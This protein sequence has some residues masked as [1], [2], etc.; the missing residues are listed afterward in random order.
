M[1]TATKIY[2]C[3]FSGSGISLLG[4]KFW[5]KGLK[6]FVCGW[7]CGRKK[8]L[9]KGIVAIWPIPFSARGK[10]TQEWWFPRALSKE[11]FIFAMPGLKEIAQTNTPSASFVCDAI[12]KWGGVCSGVFCSQF[13]RGRKFT[14][15]IYACAPALTTH[16]VSRAREGE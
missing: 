9:I 4:I 12:G 11:F 1:Q 6:V 3:I 8:A 5:F 2:D 7:F 14:I 15:S 13:W 10:N 16:S